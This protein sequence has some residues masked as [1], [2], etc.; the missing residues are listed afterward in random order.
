MC[1]CSS[2]SIHA[3]VHVNR[4]KGMYRLTPGS[5][6]V[7]DIPEAVYSPRAPELQGGAR[8]EEGRNGWPLRDLF[9]L[10]IT[11]SMLTVLN[12]HRIICRFFTCEPRR[13]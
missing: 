1:V 7:Q 10:E 9:Q 8:A 11:S 13:S 6:A 3:G 2:C 5:E 12:H 4:V